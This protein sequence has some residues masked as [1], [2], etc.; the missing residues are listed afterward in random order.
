MLEEARRAAESVQPAIPATFVCPISLSLMLDP[1][2]A[3]DGCT[4]ERSHIERWLRAGHATSPLSH[5][6][7][8]HVQLVPK[9]HVVGCSQKTSAS[10]GVAWFSGKPP[11][12]TSAKLVTSG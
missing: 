1:V 11:G 4:Y 5:E 12:R 7:L 8:A 3:A 10:F 6:P 2:V 9:K